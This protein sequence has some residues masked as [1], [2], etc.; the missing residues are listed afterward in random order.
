MKNKV[1]FFV[2]AVLVVFSMALALD[3]SATGLLD[4]IS[5]KNNETV[6][7]RK[8]EY[9][10]LLALSE[11]YAK[12]EEMIAYIEAYYY[13]EPDVDAML[14]MAQRGLLAGLED[15]YTFYYN[16]QEWSE[17]QD[18]DEGAYAGIGLQ[19]L[20][21]YN[22]ETVTVTR[23]FK[24]TPSERAG[25][26]KGDLLIRV[27]DIDVYPETLQAAVN[28]MRGTP[29]T[30]VNIEVLRG[31]EPLQFTIPRAQIQI[32]RVDYTMLE[33]QVGYILLY[34][35]AGDSDKAVED[36]LTALRADGAKS[37]VLDLRDNPGGWVASA[38]YIAD[39]FVDKSLL[40]Y[41]E[42]RFGTR[43]DYWMDDGKDDIPMV[44]LMN[45][46]SASSS[47]I[48][49]GGLQDLGRATVMGTQSFGKGIIQYVIPLSGD[50]GD[51]M[52]FTCAQYYTSSGNPVHGIGITP[53][54]VVEQPEEQQNVLFE[55]GDMS[56]I[57]LAEAWKMAVQMQKAE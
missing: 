7:V 1:R 10:E 13:K 21:D 8:T 42:D 56:D 28:V 44:I 11:R 47:E 33:D 5:G 6:T 30:Y 35:F 46:N 22:T 34:E 18:D 48:L 45:G 54:V 16:P 49:A 17:S 24:D 12:M 40:F 55:M 25:V 4:L 19:L 36:A 38:E 52:Q 27:E 3:A 50:D 43:E 57:Q 15:R 31:T 20:A 32:N 39:L 26:H 14:E 53:D 23:V 2:I 41:A 9:E 37:L 51:G 29:D